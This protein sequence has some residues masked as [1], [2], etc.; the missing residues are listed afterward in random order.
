MERHPVI[1]LWDLM[2]VVI[3]AALEAVQRVKRAVTVAAEAAASSHC[4]H[5]TGL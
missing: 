1:L 3:V 2:L 5:K 4:W